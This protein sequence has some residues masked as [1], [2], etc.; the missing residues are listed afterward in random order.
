M[1]LLFGCKVFLQRIFDARNEVVILV[2]DQVVVALATV[3]Y[4]L[5][6]TIAFQLVHTERIIC[7][8]GVINLAVKAFEIL[9][10]SSDFT[11]IVCKFLVERQLGRPVRRQSYRLVRNSG[12]ALLALFGKIRN[13]RCIVFFRSVEV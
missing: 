3:H 11:L 10:V 2:R 6:R 7:A 1:F 4:L 12:T 8:D 9:G 13:G 5:I